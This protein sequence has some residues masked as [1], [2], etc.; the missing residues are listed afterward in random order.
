MLE[1]RQLLMDCATM[2]GQNA[3]TNC[4]FNPLRKCQEGL[5]PWGGKIR[6]HQPE[7]WGQHPGEERK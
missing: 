1:G 6:G 4:T 5:A 3:A 7:Q 2:L